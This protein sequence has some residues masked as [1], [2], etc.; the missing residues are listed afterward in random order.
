MVFWP[1]IDMEKTWPGN[2][3]WPGPSPSLLGSVLNTLK[4][5][6]VWLDLPAI[7]FVPKMLL[8]SQ[9]QR[10]WFFGCLW[11]CVWAGMCVFVFSAQLPESAHVGDLSLTFLK[12]LLKVHTWITFSVA[13]VLILNLISSDYEPSTSAKACSSV[14]PMNSCSVSN[15]LALLY[16]SSLAYVTVLSDMLWQSYSVYVTFKHLCPLEQ[17][18]L[19]VTATA[20][21]SIVV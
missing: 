17:L 5:L 16:T 20:M 19:G 3:T 7:E 10:L 11:F 14:S 9:C 21:P 1:L 6:W 12:N 15:Y 8:I 2:L 13:S 18:G 4:F